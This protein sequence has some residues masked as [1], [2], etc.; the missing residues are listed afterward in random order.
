MDEGRAMRVMK[1]TP[2]A[3]LDTGKEQGN[4]SLHTHSWGSSEATYCEG[5][6]RERKIACDQPERP[7]GKRSVPQVEGPRLVDRDRE[8]RR[9][10]IS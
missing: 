2:P 6:G 8:A 3:S 9:R 1:T 10:E 4:R 7:N 5:Q